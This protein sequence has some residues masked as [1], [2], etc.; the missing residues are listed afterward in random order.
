MVTSTQATKNTP[1]QFCQILSLIYRLFRK[2][3]TKF[4]GVIIWVILVKIAISLYALLPNIISVRTLYFSKPC[5]Y[6]FL[7][8]T[9]ALPIVREGEGYWPII[10]FSDTQNFVYKSVGIVL[11]S[12]QCKIINNWCFLRLSNPGL[13]KYGAKNLVRWRLNNVL[14]FGA[15]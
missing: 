13:H 9:F 14:K 12:N 1:I 15:H 5:R 11:N 6:Q 7:W 3:C 8:T 2:M 10:I 4:Q